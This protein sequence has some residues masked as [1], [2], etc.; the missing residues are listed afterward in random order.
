MK[1]IF[2]R[3]GIDASFGNCASPIMPDDRLCWM[4][5]PEDNPEDNPD[6]PKYSEIPFEST[7]LGCIIESLSSGKILGTRTVH[8]D[9]DIFDSQRERLQGWKPAFGQSDKAA[10]HLKNQDVK[11][12]DVFLFFGWFRKIIKNSDGFQYER[13]AQNLH[14]I[15]G[16]LQIG[17]ILNV[18]E[19]DFIPPE[20]L[21]NHPH[22]LKRYLAEKNNTIYVASD[23]L[24]INGEE[25]CFNGSG[26]FD[27]L[28][29]EIT[30]TA[31]GE[32]RSVWELPSWIYPTE[33]KPPLSY[34]QNPKKWEL[35]NDIVT[36]RVP[37]RGQEF[38]LDSEHYPESQEWLLNLLKSKGKNL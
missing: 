8:L 1:I 37:G 30:L 15:Y 26:F 21:K 9:P 19:P 20:W 31:K 4:P 29:P 2:S 12:G 38:V 22:M 32:T 16:W 36:L 17:K 33:N 24:I 10:K 11:E 6:F 3:K 34:N 25:T 28:S 27:Y 14:V 23:K 18:N 7:T 13:T 5:I 35:D